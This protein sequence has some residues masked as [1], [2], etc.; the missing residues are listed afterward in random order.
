[1]L[2]LNQTCTITRNQ[3]L[4]TNGRNQQQ[5]FASAVSCLALPMNHT[6]A[7]END[8]S[9]GRAY[10]VYFDEGQD[11][12]TGDKLVIGAASYVVRAVQP[13]SL[14]LVGHVRALCEQEVN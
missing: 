8:F 9:L 2:L 7:I 1:M 6:T 14:P 11:V 3:P 12:L 5:T 4:G 13:Y 10:D